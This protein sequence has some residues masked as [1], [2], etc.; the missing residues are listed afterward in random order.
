MHSHSSLI[1][2]LNELTAF[3]QSA[4]VSMERFSFR[5]EHLTKRALIFRDENYPTS[6]FQLEAKANPVQ[7]KIHFSS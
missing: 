4:L 2:K 7:G 5:Y 6:L 3:Q 1:L